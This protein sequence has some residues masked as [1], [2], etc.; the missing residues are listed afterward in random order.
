M[1]YILLSL[2]LFTTLFA[3]NSL[4]KVSLQLKWKYQFQFAGFIMAKEKGYYEELGLDVELREFHKDINLAKSL[5]DGDSDFAVSDSALILEAMSGAPVVAMMSILQNSP[6]SLMALKSSNINSLEDINDKRISLF[7]H[8]NGMAIDAMLLSHHIKYIKSPVTFSLDKLISGENDMLTVYLSNE[9]FI[10]KELG[11]DVKLFNPKDYGFDGYGDILCTSKKMLKNRPKLVEKMY[12]ASKKGW[13][14][15]FK[16]PR[17]SVEIIYARYNTLNKSKQALQYEANILKSLS[18]YGKNFGELNK[19]K[20]KN[21]AQLFSF[22][23][24]GK[25]NLDNL[26][27]FIYEAPSI[28]EEDRALFFTPAEVEYIENTD[29]VKV[30]VHQGQSPFVTLKDKS[31]SGTSIEMLKQITK[32]TGFEFDIVRTSS[33]EEH[34]QNIKD[35]LCDISPIILTK[36]NVFNF[37]LPTKPIISDSLVLVTKINEPYVNNLHSLVNKKIA[38]Q[39]GSKNLIYYINSFYPKMDL[40][41]IENFKISRIAD[42]EFY[43]YIGGSYQIAYQISTEYFNELKIMSKIGEKQI[44]GSF[45]ISTREPI[46]WSIFN[47]SIDNVSQLEKQQIEHAWLSVKVA[48]EFDYSGFIKLL[49]VTSIIIL[50]LMYFYLKQKKLH[51][52]IKSL[53]DTL[54]IRIEEEVEKNKQQQ[55]VLLHQSRLA[56]MG[57]IIQNITHQ[58]RQPLAQIN[59]AVLLLDTYINQKEIYDKRIDT[60]L[61]EIESTTLYMS[62]T[63]N[64]FQYYFNPKKEKSIFFLKDLIEDS[65]SIVKPALK[66]THIDI[67]TYGCNK[68][69][70]IGYKNELQQVVIVLLNNA[71]D[72]LTSR[73]IISPKIYIEIMNLE[74]S[75][76]IS[77][78]DNADG[79]KKDIIYKIF[80]PYFTTKHKSQGTGLGLYLSKMIIEEGMGG[81]LTVKNTNIGACFKIKIFKEEENSGK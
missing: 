19:Y 73:Y 37:L 28:K 47:K 20:V 79:I 11:L 25:R 76:D 62:Q 4:E 49:S 33:H 46:L 68:C 75:Y 38:I 24:K 1:K 54:E 66:N 15:A 23:I 81:K 17:E 41:E 34:M 71:Q 44:N 8:L 80:E 5:Q 12:E 45:G 32:R 26:D 74:T 2:I 53:H 55:L 61:A 6:Y 57:E 36:P 29:I 18:G 72:A 48:K 63:I 64:D 69:K 40:I 51:K 43:G 52:K 65:I 7:H 27:D 3:Q 78:S 50:I 58:W 67:V 14:Y 60:K 30:C 42:E 31:I 39:K 9:P 77:I 21:I 70:Y 56:Q 16:H 35:G 13:K 59:S 22:I 10:A